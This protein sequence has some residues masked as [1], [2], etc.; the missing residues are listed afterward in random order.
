MRIDGP[1][2]SCLQFGNKETGM[3]KMKGR[4][5]GMQLQARQAE[6]KEQNMPRKV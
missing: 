5:E 1:Q 4:Q 6:R 2:D 3:S